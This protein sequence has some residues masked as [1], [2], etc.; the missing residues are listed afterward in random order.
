MRKRS[1]ARASVIAKIMHS[2]SGG[3]LFLRRAA[4]LYSSVGDRTPVKRLAR[5][6]TDRG[7]R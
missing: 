7:V 6:A 3:R 4:R 1:K 2:S 5:E